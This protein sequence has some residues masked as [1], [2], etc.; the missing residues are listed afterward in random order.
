[1]EIED[2]AAPADFASAYATRAHI[3]AALDAL[4]V[5][6][7][8]AVVLHHALG[9]SAAEIAEELNAPIETIRSRLRVGMQHLRSAMTSDSDGDSR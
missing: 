9:M 5:E 1:M 3:A 6:Q 7:R 8:F 2:V 4:P